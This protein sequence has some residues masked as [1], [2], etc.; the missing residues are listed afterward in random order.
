MDFEEVL[1]PHLLAHSYMW[2]L[3]VLPPPSPGEEVGVEEEAPAGGG[4]EK[5]EGGKE[6]FG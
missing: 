6:G 3:S 2:G 1:T 4:N 5:Q